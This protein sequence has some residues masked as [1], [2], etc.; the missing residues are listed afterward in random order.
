MSK[1]PGTNKKVFSSKDY[2]RPGLSVDEIEE[3]K[4]AFD[5]FDVNKDGHIS[6]SELTKAMET[7][8]FDS[9]NEAI[10]KMIKEMDQD[11]SGTIDF[12]EFLDMM[13]ARISDQ[14]TREDL[15]RVYKLFDLERNGDIRLHD[16][17]RVARELG[18]DIS[19]QELE[20]I[21]SRADLDGDGKL[22]FEDFYNVIVRKT[23]V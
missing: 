9:K 16:L 13:T 17:K 20:E 5:I 2:E 1:R 6:I 15:E 23:F 8:G 22:S 11:G 21:I 10:Y 7:L 12:A 18:E 3:I 14:N 4:E 19:D